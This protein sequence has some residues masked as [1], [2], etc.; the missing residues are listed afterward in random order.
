[1]SLNDPYKDLDR[2]INIGH[3]AREEARE[4]AR[5]VIFVALGAAALLGCVWLGV[6][7]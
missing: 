2:E 6:A 5:S 7:F 1:M 4:W 3:H